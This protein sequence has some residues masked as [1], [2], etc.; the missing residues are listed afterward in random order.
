MRTNSLVAALVAAIIAAP[1]AAAD[2]AIADPVAHLQAFNETCRSHFPNFEA[3]AA[4]AVAHGWKESTIRAVG[5]G[6][7]PP[8]MPRA[9][10]K[11]EYMLFLI[12]P[13]GKAFTQVCQVAGNATTKLTAADVAAVVSPSLNAGVPVFEQDKGRDVAIWRIA[14]DTSISAGISIYG[15]VRT[16]GM[17][18]RR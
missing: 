16:I 10:Y 12:R 9:F 3:I 17:M 6:A 5:G 13:E 18:E 11:G 8:G 2:K 14:P 7:L 4:D 15:K 1:V